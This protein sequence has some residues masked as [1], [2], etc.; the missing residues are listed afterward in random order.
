MSSTRWSAGGRVYRTTSTE[1]LPELNTT[2][3]WARAARLVR[4]TGGKLVTVQKN[5]VLL[6]RPVPL[7][8]RMFA[9]FGALGPAICPPG[10]GE[11]LLRGH[12][13]EGIRV[14][15]SGVSEYDRPAG[16]DLVCRWGWDTVSRGVR[17]NGVP[18]A[19]RRRHRLLPLPS[20]TSARVHVRDDGFDR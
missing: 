20:P 13:A 2:Y 11:S 8:E 17:V 19:H 18:A 4:V 1:E 7:W 12:F 14:V 5:A 10:W 15:L 3:V 6:E 9:T 16:L